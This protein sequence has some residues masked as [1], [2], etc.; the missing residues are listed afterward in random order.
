MATYGRHSQGMGN[1]FS[2][3]NTQPRMPTNWDFTGIMDDKA[4]RHVQQVYVTLAGAVGVAALG[5]MLY[6]QTHM[7]LW[8]PAIASFGL[9]MWLAATPNSP[10]NLAKRQLQ[11]G[12]VALCQGMVIAPLI[13][14]NLQVDPGLLLTAFGCTAALFGCFTAAAFLARRRQYLFIGGALGSAM[15]MLM[16]I[17]LVNMFSRSESLWTAELYLGLLVFSGYVVFDTQLI[18]ERAHASNPDPVT[19]AL[20][21]F[22]DAVGLL[23]RIIVIL[24]KNKN[25]RE[26]RS[27]NNRR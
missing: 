11:L 20:Q 13:E 1:F 10:S 2:G 9:L 27:N 6:M 24:M 22:L 17:R 18:I 3:F 14:V 12:G 26:R 5:V 4:Q 16:V 19:D 15:S 7:S 8:L 25:K 23:V 21:L